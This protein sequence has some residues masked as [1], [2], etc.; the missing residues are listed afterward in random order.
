MIYVNLILVIQQFWGRESK[1]HSCFYLLYS[2]P[3]PGLTSYHYRKTTCFFYLHFQLSLLIY[4]GQVRYLTKIEK[5][6]LL[7]ILDSH[8]DLL[9]TV[10]QRHT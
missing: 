9:D 3:V 6:I 5:S 4:N 2:T 8:T 1:E 7:P 10:F